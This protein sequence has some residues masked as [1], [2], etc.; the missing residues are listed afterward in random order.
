MPIPELQ[1]ETWSHQGAVSQSSD[2]YGVVKS[3]L[4]RP[5][6]GYWS[7]SVEI[8]LQGSYSNDTNIFR[9]SDVDVVMRLN[10]TFHHGLE[11][12]SLGERERFH[13]VF[14]NAAYDFSTFKK[15]VL[16]VLQAEF[17]ADVVPGNRAI[18]IKA[19]QRRR[20]TDVLVATEFRN[21]RSFTN[22]EG[23]YV[24]GIC[25]FT[26][27][28]DRIVN[29]PKQHRDNCVRKHQAT[30]GWF[31]PTVRILKNLRQALIERGMLELSQAPSYFL[32]G[33]IYNVPDSKFGGSFSN[34]VVNSV[35]WILA[36]DRTTFVCPNG[37][38]YL[39]RESPVTWSP[40]NC[41]RFLDALKS[42]WGSW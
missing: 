3:V 13:S 25:F 40:L 22:L 41:D 16:S 15:D 8:F 42:L 4:E 28:G 9:E 26:A 18:K 34:T 36:A 20:K 24:S 21:Y 19:N 7:K 10:D 35:N 31:K 12:L 11:N 37:Q 23:E 30:N 38:F 5:G 6:S 2:T 27:A 14:S 17:G 39:L 33:L 29:Y 1:L 32:E